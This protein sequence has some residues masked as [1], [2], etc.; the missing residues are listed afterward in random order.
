MTGRRPTDPA[1]PTNGS[2]PESHRR[3]EGMP[4]GVRDAA[5]R[6]AAVLLTAGRT[7]LELALLELEEARLHVERLWIGAIVTLFLVF[8]TCALLL[9]WLLLAVE[10]AQRSTWAG[11]LALAFAG[12]AAVG[13]WRWWHT[14]RRRR[15]W[16]ADSLQALRDDEEA[17]RPTRANPSH[18]HPLAAQTAQPAQP[19]RTDQ[20]AQEARAWTR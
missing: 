2:G 13:A 1:N 20:T 15:P 7:R 14:A 12:A 10:A 5:A 3:T 6:W 11:A 8:I 16:L 17:L 18:D 4:S 9:T 19:A